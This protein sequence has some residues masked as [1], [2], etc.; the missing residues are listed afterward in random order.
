MDRERECVDIRAK[1][2]GHY[3]D[4]GAWVANQ[5][6]EAPVYI[7]GHEGFA[8]S[9]RSYRDQ[10]RLA[11]A[12]RAWARL[13][14]N[15]VRASVG[16]IF[17]REDQEYLYS[18]QIE[19]LWLLGPCHG[20]GRLKFGRDFDFNEDG[21]LTIMEVDRKEGSK[22]DV[23]SRFAAWGE[24][25]TLL[26]FSRS[27]KATEAAMSY[28]SQTCLQDNKQLLTGWDRFRQ[29]SSYAE[30]VGDI[31]SPAGR[32]D[33]ARQ[34]CDWLNKEIISKLLLDMGTERGLCINLGKFVA[35]DE[36]SHRRG[37]GRSNDFDWG[38]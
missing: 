10:D 6:T 4:D 9:V 38:I 12:N 28:T 29:R 8:R 21:V 16:E 15:E 35:T 32:Y 34:I 33:P 5:K 3:D 24:S 14:S 27:D 2:A 11:L 31:D 37:S 20:G 30:H 23:W 25:K 19:L 17:D 13:P 26:D 1:L 7:G 22:Q 18:R 36:L